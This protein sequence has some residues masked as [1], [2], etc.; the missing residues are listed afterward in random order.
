[1]NSR[2]LYFITNDSVCQVYLKYLQILQ[3]TLWLR[4]L[5]DGY[6]IA[7]DSVCSICQILRKFFR[8]RQKMGGN[9]YSNELLCI[10]STF[11]FI[12]DSLGNET[13]VKFLFPETLSYYE[14][15]Q[16]HYYPY[17]CYCSLTQLVLEPLYL[18]VRLTNRSTVAVL[19]WQRCCRW[20]L[21]P[22]Q[23]LQQTK[24]PSGSFHGM[25]EI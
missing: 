1:M 4:S 19:R 20:F 24:T 23:P 11:S 3:I 17:R 10:F 2:E 12:H 18:F 6:F 16:H 15:Y 5:R 14:C 8:L 7:K 25:A 21:L 9:L 13:L 22:K